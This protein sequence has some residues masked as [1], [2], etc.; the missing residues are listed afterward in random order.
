MMRAKSRLTPVYP[1]L[2]RSGES[3]KKNYQPNNY[4]MKINQKMKTL[5]PL[6]AFAGLALSANAAVTSIDFNVGASATH[7][8][9]ADNSAGLVLTGATTWNAFTLASSSGQEQSITTAEGPTFT[10][11]PGGGGTAFLVL[12]QIGGAANDLRGDMIAKN[13]VGDIPWEL[14][15]LD[16]N[17]LYSLV[18]FGHPNYVPNTYPDGS[19]TTIDGVGTGATAGASEW[20]YDFTNVQAVGGEISGTF[21]SP[22]GWNTWSGLQFEQTG[23]VPEPSTT[24]LLGLGGLALILRRRK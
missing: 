2:D 19:I 6:A 9:E 23:V 3:L 12:N 14:T 13:D 1:R 4:M 16:P 5:L 24:A 10:I 8:G 22:A 20:D 7:T 15:G 21:V 18:F 17:G 11:N